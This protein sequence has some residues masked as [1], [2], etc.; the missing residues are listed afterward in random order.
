MYL[1]KPSTLPPENSVTLTHVNSIL[2]LLAA[3]ELCIL[4]RFV[5]KWKSLVRE[6]RAASTLQKFVRYRLELRDISCRIL[7]RFMLCFGLKRSVPCSVCSKSMLPNRKP[8]LKCNCGES[9]YCSRVCQRVHWEGGHRQ[10]HH[11]ASRKTKQ[12]MVEIRIKSCSFC[13]KRKSAEHDIKGRCSRCQSVYYC[14]ATCQKNHW[15]THKLICKRVTKK[16]QKQK[17]ESK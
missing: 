14:D 15:P 8:R 6:K 17:Q 11:R 12:K 9:Q 7:Q 2:H 13:N 10:T 3:N 5:N 1:G 16:K 4:K